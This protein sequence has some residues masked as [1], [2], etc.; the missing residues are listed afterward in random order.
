MSLRGGTGVFY[1]VIPSQLCGGAHYTPP[2]YVLTT[3]SPQTAPLLPLYTFGESRDKPIP[4]ST[5]AR[6]RG[7]H[8]TG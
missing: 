7:R 8:R 4:L 1:D 2:I 3:A 5:A 6:I